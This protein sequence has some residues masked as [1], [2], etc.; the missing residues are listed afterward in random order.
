MRGEWTWP[1]PVVGVDARSRSGASRC[2]V[3]LMRLEAVR[4]VV[5]RLLVSD[6][7]D[8]RGS[9]RFE[10]NRGCEPTP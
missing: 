10:T 8:G 1:A 6:P 3:Q 7:P 9:V 5:A 4:D 2:G